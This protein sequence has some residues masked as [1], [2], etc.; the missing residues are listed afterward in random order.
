MWSLST[1]QNLTAHFDACVTRAVGRKS[2]PSS[3]PRKFKPKAFSSLSKWCL[4]RIVSR[5]LT[6]RISERLKQYGLVEVGPSHLKVYHSLEVTGFYYDLGSFKAEGLAA[7]AAVTV[8]DQLA[9]RWALISL[10]IQTYH[11]TDFLYWF[12]LR[13]YNFISAP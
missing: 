11:Y 5:K 9:S 2:W 4:N 7:I 3:R 13:A 6:H 1:G 8:I 12:L 10:T